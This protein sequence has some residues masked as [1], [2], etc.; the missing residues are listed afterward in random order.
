MVLYFL[1]YYYLKA[2][3]KLSFLSNKSNLFDSYD[4]K[5]NRIKRFAILYRNECDLVETGTY[6]GLTVDACLKDFKNIYTIEL[7]DRLFKFNFERFKFQNSVNILHGDSSIRLKELLDSKSLNKNCVF[8]L[9]GHYSDKET[10]L[11][12][13]VSPII[14]ELLS[15]FKIVKEEYNWIVLIDDLRLFDGIEYPSLDEVEQLALENNFMMDKDGDCIILRRE[16][17]FL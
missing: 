5:W 13:K 17:S 6:Y 11:S 2:K 4:V 7:N 15:I 14:E 12:D 16:T 10:S 8:W 3:I 1:K 9:D